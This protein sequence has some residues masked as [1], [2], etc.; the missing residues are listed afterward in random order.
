MFPQSY[1]QNGGR[2]KL[3]LG[4]QTDFRKPSFALGIVPRATGYNR[5]HRE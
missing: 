1:S 5:F 2:I 3:T 4:R